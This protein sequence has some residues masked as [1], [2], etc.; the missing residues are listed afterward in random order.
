MA[1]PSD[2]T[3]ELRGNLT[4]PEDSGSSVQRKYLHLKPDWSL[5]RGLSNKELE[6]HLVVRLAGD[7]EKEGL[8]GLGSDL[9]IGEVSARS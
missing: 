3:W 8:R 9:S 1:H 6:G 4:S 7:Q 5:E 2:L